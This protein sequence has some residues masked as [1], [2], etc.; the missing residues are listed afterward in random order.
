VVYTNTGPGDG[1]ISL[2]GSLI[3]YTNLEPIIDNLTVAQRVIAFGGAN[4]QINV[5]VGGSR[6]VVA[7]PSSETIDFVNPGANGLVVVQGGAGNDNFTI[8]GNPGYDLLID[9]GG[10]SNTVTSTTPITV[11]VPGTNGDDT[12]DVSQAGP[13]VTF[14]VNG[15]ISSVTGAG[16]LLVDA[17]DGNDTVTLHSLT[18]PATVDAGSG[19]D[20]VNGSGVAAANLLLIG[21]SGNDIL[22]GGAGNDQ[23]EGGAGEDFLRGGAGNDLLLGGDGNDSL[24]G[25]AGRDTLDGGA[26]SNTAVVDRIEPI[27][28]WNINEG[29]GTFIGDSAGTPQNGTFFVEHHHDDHD[30]DGGH[31]HQP[32][33]DD[34]GPPV[35]LAP[36]GAQTGA[37]FHDDNDEYIAVRHDPVFEVAQ[38]TIQLWFKTD[39]AS[40]Q[41][42]LFSKDR[43]GNGAGHLKI[44]IDDRDL[45][46]RLQN[47]NQSFEIDTDDTAFNNLV[48]SNKWY[49][50]TFTFG[51]GGM[52]LYLDGALV[53]SNSYTGGLV[54][55]R[56][57]IVIGGSNSENRNDSGD[58]SE[59]RITD[60]FDGNIDE[61]SF[62]GTALSAEQIA[63]SRFRG[64]MGI[65][66]PEDLGTIDGTDTL[67][68]IQKI[69][70]TDGMVVNVPPSSASLQIS[71]AGGSTLGG[72]ISTDVSGASNHS[73]LDVVHRVVEGYHYGLMDTGD[74]GLGGLMSSSAAPALFSVAGVKLGADG[75][76]ARQAGGAATDTASDDWSVGTQAGS[77]TGV[78]SVDLQ[79]IVDS[80]VAPAEG[81]VNWSDT[82]GWGSSPALAAG[83][84]GSSRTGAQPNLSEFDLQLVKKP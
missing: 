17:L 40:E 79:A 82:G 47:G 64:A 57:P 75:T 35:S 5:A 78:E 73:W 39:D 61:V 12:I 14:N 70:F 58:L 13:T 51:P 29:H 68:N 83:A 80:Q 4:D 8:S 37:D 30:H 36:F 71:P 52:K 3:T 32:D 54:G 23:L 56:Q 16:H 69:A 24:T 1:S 66:R 22:T 7:S 76:G 48:R 65:V 27:A 10:G 41:Q 18:T 34:P 9:V 60:P 33:L 6:T 44:W 46:V 72:W 45:K 84:S 62:Y 31:N 63:Q 67:R 42:A 26:G 2:D 19:N 38:G 74:Q 59:I 25:G 43:D 53:S 20:L 77:S 50:L 21:G 11:L 49:Q 15:A 28:Y 55:N 81:S